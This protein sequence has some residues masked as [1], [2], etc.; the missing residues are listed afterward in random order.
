MRNYDP[1]I[2]KLF[3]SLSAAER[4][5]LRW[6]LDCGLTLEAATEL[7]EEGLVEEKLKGSEPISS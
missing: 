5:N 3:D 7:F 2:T 1:K 6:M 4:E